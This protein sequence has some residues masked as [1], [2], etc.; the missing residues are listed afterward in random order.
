MSIDCIVETA[1]VKY[2]LLCSAWSVAGLMDCMQQDDPA[3][4]VPGCRPLLGRRRC[5]LDLATPIDACRF[6][7][8]HAQ[9]GQRGA[10]TSP[11]ATCRVP[12]TVRRG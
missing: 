6:F 11:A 5:S 2:G 7:Y 1:D 8:T 3:F 4:N 9:A 10:R 12:A